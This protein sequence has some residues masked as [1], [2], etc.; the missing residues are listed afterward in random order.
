MTPKT[1]ERHVKYIFTDPELLQI[2]KD[3][4]DKS[5]ALQEL[6]GAKKRVTSDFGAKIAAAESEIGILS[7][8]ISTGAEYR[9]VKCSQELNSPVLGKKTIRRNDTFEAIETVDMTQEEMQTTLEFVE[10]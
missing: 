2:G 10:K 7:R 6:N 8:N 4:A 5:N 3:L 1:I 9:M